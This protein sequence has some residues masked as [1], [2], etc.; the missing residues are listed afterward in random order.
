MLL[1]VG[2]DATETDSH[3]VAGDLPGTAWG[4]AAEERDAL[5]AENVAVIVNLVVANDDAVDAVGVEAAE[6]AAAL[7]LVGKQ[8]AGESA[9]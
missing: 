5:T 9:P 3:F 4:R 2:A 1:A 6:P 7:A 8:R